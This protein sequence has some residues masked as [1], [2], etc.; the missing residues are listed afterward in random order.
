MLNLFK[1]T[2]K[3][4][5]KTLG[6]Q[7]YIRNGVGFGF[8]SDVF[9]YDNVYLEIGFGRS[10]SGPGDW[11]GGASRAQTTPLKVSIDKNHII[12]KVET[13]SFY[14]SDSS[15]KLEKVAKKL[16]KKLKIGSKLV[17]EDQEFKSSVDAILNVIP[18][19]RHIGWDVYEHPHMLKN[20]TSE[21]NQ[22]LYD[23]RDPKNQ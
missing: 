18:C 22:P 14:N 16:M 17:F 20:Y 10:I 23:F 5:F 4:I 9:L 7:A 2:D 3:K 19:K 1:V 13:D 21:E 11:G 12:Q 15:Q 8:I 6:K